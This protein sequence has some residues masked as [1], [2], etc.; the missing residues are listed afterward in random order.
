METPTITSERAQVVTVQPE[1]LS[2]R[3]IV[4]A[5]IEF[6]NRGTFRSWFS[7]QHGTQWNPMIRDADSDSPI[8]KD[9]RDVFDAERA[10]LRHSLSAIVSN[11]VDKERALEW[12]RRASS[13]SLVPQFT[14]QNGQL[15]VAY[16]HH[17][18]ARYD[19]PPSCQFAYALLLLLDTKRPYGDALC[20][21]RLEKCGKF[22]W[23][24][25]PRTGRPQRL[26]CSHEHMQ[27][28]HEA[29]AP[30][31]VRDSRDRK[32][33]KKARNRRRT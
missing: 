32:R 19:S 7:L 2:E 4:E 15:H 1:P 9:L 30:K 16:R 33:A 23:V 12:A 3:G 27:L 31:R 8:M 18:G 21:C 25:R 14:F 29:R 13:L 11:S 26:Y 10:D 6:A 28:A 24:V 5:L 22:F 20:K 17:E